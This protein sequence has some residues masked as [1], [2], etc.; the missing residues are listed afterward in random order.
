M[1]DSNLA[2]VINNEVTNASESVQFK[3]VD[4]QFPL[5][6]IMINVKSITADNQSSVFTVAITYSDNNI[7]W[8][9]TFVNNKIKYNK[10][11]QLDIVVSTVGKYE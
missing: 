3:I 11:N 8:Y 1:K 10:M 6:F 2:L 4:Q 7:I 9:V 5:E